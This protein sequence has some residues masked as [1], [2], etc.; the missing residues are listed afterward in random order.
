M[1]K[2]IKPSASKYWGLVGKTFGTWLVKDV[3]RD[4]KGLGFL[5]KCV[6]SCGNASYLRGNHLRLGR[7]TGCA[8]CGNNKKSKDLVN[9][10]YGTFTVLSEVKNRAR[11]SWL[12]RCDCGNEFVRNQGAIRA[13]GSKVTGCNKCRFSF[14]T[15][16]K[17]GYVTLTLP[18]D[19]NVKTRGRV[20]EHVAVMSR[21]LGRPLKDTETVHHKNGVKWDNRLENLELWCSNHTPGQRVTDMVEWALSHLRQ[22][23]PEKLAKKYRS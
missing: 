10:R 14:K 7:T 3:I 18:T 9:E 2:K 5:C 6:C 13:N 12:C 16:D 22:Y 11:K 21:H 20:L 4:T 17:K 1:A 19:P 23:A 15:M 8:K